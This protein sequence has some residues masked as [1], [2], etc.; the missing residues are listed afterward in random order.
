MKS[1]TRDVIDLHCDAL[2]ECGRRGTGFDD[3]ALQFSLQ[4]LPQ[5][6][7]LCQLLAIFVPDSLRGD[8]AEAHFMRLAGVLAEQMERHGDRITHVKPGEEI[9]DALARAPIAAMLSIEGGA[10]LNG[11]IENV[12]SFYDM[13]V[14]LITLTWN[15]ENELGGG[16]GTDLGLKPFG[17][18]VVAEMETLGVAVDASH[19]S[20]KAF[21]D[22][23]EAAQKPFV[24]SHSNARA[25]CG[26]PRN[27]NDEMFKEI[28]RRGGVA[29][30]NFCGDFIRSDGVDGTIDDLMRHAHHFLELGGENAICFGSDF[31]GCNTPDYLQDGISRFEYVAESLE[32][33]GIPAAV[34]D[35]IMYG[36]ANRYFRQLAVSNVR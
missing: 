2:F 18:E 5:G 8:D 33:S 22:L 21:W 34:V 1:I 15:G 31:D 6:L 20:D 16:A 26:H 23:C 30:L 10:A 7:R 4:K 13:G 11:K 24:A 25:I 32:R 14:R 28:A 29:G 35:K 27:L 17:C 19:L 3:P 12:R 36:N 9:S